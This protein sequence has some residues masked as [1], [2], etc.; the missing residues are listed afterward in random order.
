MRRL[1]KALLPRPILERLWRWRRVIEFRTWTAED[2]A[3]LEFYRSFVSPGDLVFDVGANLGNRTKIFLRLGARVVAFEPQPRCAGALRAALAREPRFTL[4]TKALGRTEGR[5]EMRLNDTHVLS[6]L[7]KAWVE[8][9]TS[10]GRFR[11]H[12]WRDQITVEVTTLDAM[13]RQLG[14]PAF[15][16]ID[17]EGFEKEVIAGLST[18]VGALSMEFATESLEGI[19][20]SIEHLQQLGRVE[21]QFSAG[22]SM[23]LAWPSWVSP[24]EATARLRAL[25]GTERLAWGDVYVRGK[26]L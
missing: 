20:A 18:P 21:C 19:A 10:S 1:L 15:L 11:G 12:A 23:A 24:A 14:R 6:T 25:A 5:A 8:S 16:K 22:E 4:V 2:D 9:T 7:S 3:R 17:T 13:I 26:V